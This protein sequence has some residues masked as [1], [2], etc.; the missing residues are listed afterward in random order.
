MARMSIMF[1]GF[2]NLAHAI[3]YHGGDLKAAVNEALTQ[4]GDYVQV[5]TNKA[6]LPYAHGGLKGYATGEMFN[7]LKK[8]N[9]VIWTSPTVAEVSVGFNLSAK[10]GFHSIFVMYGTPRM[11][12]DQKLYNAIKGA[13]T[14]KEVA[15]IQD[16]VMQMALDLTYSEAEAAHKYSGR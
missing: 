4:T 6:S 2:Q 3:D 1:D 8:D 14:R 10:G 9:P 13:K 12:K 11:A 5:Q 15:L 16:E 7:A